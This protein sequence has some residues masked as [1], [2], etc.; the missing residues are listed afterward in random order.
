M[1]DPAAQLWTTL[2][3][4]ATVTE[5]APLTEQRGARVPDAI[6]RLKPG[7]TAD[8]ARAQMDQIADAL[9]R[10]YPDNNKNIATTSVVPE[11]ERLT[12]GARKP[13]WILLGAV[14]LVLFIGMRQCREPAAGS[15]HRTRARV[16]IATARWAPRARL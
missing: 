16:R 6:G 15:Q 14:A 13:L 4:D 7:V 8:Q 12:G 11:L 10:Q 2:S 9:T 5:F 3:E 1:D